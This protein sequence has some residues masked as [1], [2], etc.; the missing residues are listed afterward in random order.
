M[1]DFPEAADLKEHT[2]TEHDEDTKSGYMQKVRMQHFFVKLDITALQCALCEKDLLSVEDLIE[3]LKVEHEKPMFTDIKSHIMPFKFEDSK[4]KCSFCPHTFD[5]FKMLQEHMYTHYD[6]YVCDVC[7]AGFV[8]Q[9]MLANHSVSHK[10]GRFK[11]THCDEEFETIQKK[12]YHEKMVH[13]MSLNKCGYCDEKFLW[14]PQKCAHMAEVHGKAIMKPQECKAC[15]K[16]FESKR[17]LQIHVRRDHLLERRFKCTE[18]EMEFFTKALLKNHMV[19]HSGVKMFPCKVCNKSYSLMKGLREHMKIHNNDK[20][21]KCVQRNVNATIQ[22]GNHKNVTRTR[23]R[24]EEPKDIKIN[25]ITKHRSNIHLIL[26]CTNAT[27]IR[28]RGGIGYA[29]SFCA[30]EFPDPADLKKHTIEVHDD[31]AKLKFMHGKMMFS[32]KKSHEKSVH[33]HANLLNK[34]GYCQ[35]KFTNYKKKDEHLVKVHGVTMKTI[36]CHACDKT[37]DNKGALSTHTKRDHLM[38]RKHK[39]TECDMGFFL[40][41]ELKLHMVKHTGERTFKCTVCSKSYGRHKT[42]REHM[43]IHNDDRRFKCDHTKL[44]KESIKIVWS[45]AKREINKELSKKYSNIE[46]VLTFSNATPILRWSDLGYVCC[47]C[48][49]GFHDPADLKKHTIATHSDKCNPVTE[50]AGNVRRKKQHLPSV[51]VKLDITGLQCNKGKVNAKELEKVD[52]AVLVIVEGGKAVKSKATGKPKITSRSLLEKHQHNLKVILKSSNAT[53]ILRLGGVGYM[54]SYCFKEF[55]DPKDLKEHY[56]ESHPSEQAPEG[57]SRS[58]TFSEYCIKLDITNLCCNICDTEIDNLEE[59]SIHLQEDH[60]EFM[61]TNIPSHIIPFK[62]DS[63]QLTC[64]LCSRNFYRFKILLE[65]MHTHFRNYVCEI[66]DAGFINKG[67]LSRHTNI[68]RKGVFPCSFCCKVFDTNIK[69]RV[70]E[71]VHTSSKSLNRCGYCNEGFKEHH[72]KEVHLFEVH[73]VSRMDYKCTACD[74]GFD[75]KRKLRIHVKRDHLLERKHKCLYCDMSFFTRY[76]VKKHMIT[77]TGEK[78]FQCPVC[79]KAFGRKSTLVEHLRIHNDDRR[80][81]C[82]HCGMAFVQKYEE[83]KLATPAKTKKDPYTEEIG[84]NNEGLIETGIKKAPQKR[85]K[86]L[87]YK[88]LNNLKNILECTNATMILRQGDKGYSCCYCDAAYAKPSQLKVH[89]LTAHAKEEVFYGKVYA[90]GPS[91]FLVKLD[92]TDLK[93]T[94]CDTDLETLENIYEHLKEKHEKSFHMDIKN[95][96][97]PFRFNTEQLTC[98]LCPNNVVFDTFR[99]L[100]E[101]MH[102]HYRNFIC[103]ACD[104]GFINQISLKRHAVIHTKGTFKCRYCSL[105]FDNVFK[106]RNHEGRA[107]T[108]ADKASICQLCNE[109]FKEYWLKELHLTKAHGL[110]PKKFNCSACDKT[111]STPGRRLPARGRVFV[112]LPPVLLASDSA[113]RDRVVV[114]VLGCPRCLVVA[115]RVGRICVWWEWSCSSTPAPSAAYWALECVCGRCGVC[116]VCKPKE[117]IDDK[118]LNDTVSDT[119]SIPENDL[120]NEKDQDKVASRTDLTKHRNNIK[121]ILL[122][123]NATPIR[124]HVGIGYT[125]SYCEDQYVKAADLKRHTLDIHKKI[126]EANFMKNMN[127]S[128]YVVKVDITG[129]KC[130]GRGTRIIKI[131]KPTKPTVELKFFSKLTTRESSYS[132]AATETV[133]NR[134]NLRHILLNSNANTIRCKDALG[135]GCSFCPKQFQDPTVL[136]KHCLDEHNSDKLILRMTAKIFEYVIKLD[137]TYLNCALCDEDFDQLDEFMVHLKNVHNKPMCLDVKSYILP[138][139][140]DTPALKCVMCLAE[141]NSFKLLQEHMNSH[142]A[143][144]F[145]EI[146]GAGFVTDRLRVSHVRRHESGEYKCD[147]CEKTFANKIRL[148]EHNKRTHL[149]FSARNKCPYCSEKFNDYW[150]KMDHMIKEHGVEQPVLKCSACDRTFSTQRSLSVH[151]KKDHLMERRH[152][153]TECDMRFFGMSGL[154]KHMTKHTGLRQFRCEICLK[155]YGRKN[156]LREHMR[157]HA[158]DRRFVCVHCGQAFVQK[159]VQRNTRLKEDKSKREENNVLVDIEPKAEKQQETAKS[160]N[161]LKLILLHSNATLIR[162]K[163]SDGYGCNFCRKKFEQPKNLKAHSLEEHSD[164]QALRMPR[165]SQH[166]LKADITDLKCKICD[167]N[168]LK[169]DDLAEHLKKEHSKN[170]TS[171]I[172]EI[173]PF[174]FDNEG[175]VCAICGAGYSTFKILQE[176]MHNHFRNHVCE[177][178]S[179]GFVTKRLL[180]SHRRRHGGESQFKCGHCEKSFLCA[181]K[182]RD[183]EQRMHLGIKKRNK[184]KLCEEKFEDYWT[185]QNHMVQKHGAPPI[186]LK[187]TACDRTFNN[188]RSLT[189]HVKKDHLM[190]REHVCSV[191]NA[192]Y[193]LKRHL[194]EHMIMHTGLRSRTIRDSSPIIFEEEDKTLTLDRKLNFSSFV[195]IRPVGKKAIPWVREQQKKIAE[196]R[197]LTELDW[198]F[199]NIKTILKCSNAS[200]VRCRVGSRF[201]CSYCLDQFQNPTELRGHSIQVHANDKPEFFNARSL[202][203]HIVYL[204]I[205]GTDPD[206]VRIEIEVDTTL[207]MTDD[208]PETSKINEVDRHRENVRTILLYSNA[209]PIGRYG[210]LGYTC[211]YCPQIFSDPKDLKKHVIEQHDERNI[212]SYM[213][214]YTMLNYIVKLDITG[215][216][217]E[218]CLKPFHE[219]QGFIDHLTEEHDKF[220]HTDIGNH[221]VP[222]RF[223]SE[224]LRCVQCSFEY[225]NF[226]ILLEH[227]NTHFSNHICGVCEAG[228]VNRRMLQAHMYRHKTGVFRCSF[229]TKV[230]DTRVKMKVHERMVHL[231]LKKRPRCTIC[232][233]KFLDFQKMIEH[234]ANDHGLQRQFKCEMCSRMFTSQQSFK[235][236]KKLHCVTAE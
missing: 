126:T 117:N 154:K 66:C 6:N 16:I 82:Q 71:R 118:E 185:K 182:R 186:A 2:I 70:H 49:E 160:S 116:P 59:L 20:R 101:H 198:Q 8:N 148:R 92:I 212:S 63:D 103:D 208:E 50:P 39:C 213:K 53:P 24:I 48:K 64:C 31:K 178:C 12:R 4:L 170:I 234:E 100:H 54:C 155:A 177:V 161:D 102:K 25:E 183:H 226:K 215:L 223:D 15:N 73:G 105:I 34:C 104:A 129:L 224:N 55:P 14:Y 37:F 184:C 199:D 67:C 219:L 106:R 91:R 192:R 233:K 60:E 214:N 201:A 86:R 174:K 87:L 168:L 179:A 191:C 75:T 41:N 95:Q 124:R 36:R 18:C 200:P 56:F 122:N 194:M 65:H 187:C 232:G 134:A 111:F 133:K 10:V 85:I 151:T 167:K 176:H 162:N 84:S 77:H 23:R 89:T 47:Y 81:K 205:T 1:E 203:R 74:R 138:F 236:H 80:F 28:C 172:S 163:D 72:L 11:C 125:C 222:F 112:A 159:C 225:N 143:N 147:Q 130:H 189:R 109:G 221:I 93:C 78:E 146:C 33:I 57:C 228:F 90:R 150:K 158:N 40:P 51:S 98:C 207:F 132:L 175:L 135:Y 108:R 136:K 62:F 79:L 206:S 119:E 152:K 113:G 144:Y 216:R 5:R 230:F 114:W 110:T 142:F 220:F 9:R 202:S 156:T 3:H 190:E 30:D 145:C 88:H 52:S 140:F 27:P 171:G 17:K 7:H 96:I 121:E 217:C 235:I 35:M 94:L 128:E 193:F 38:E 69:K 45:K 188:R 169:L 22:L 166:L 42:L 107:H 149:G 115:E 26:Q 204:D 29:C 32:K 127:L 153:C 157:I 21:F 211:C 19:K 131:E 173:I 44:S 97:F 197:R 83:E 141:F 120:F 229:C 165:S 13:L 195:S 180:V 58:T 164:I 46:T 76:D 181:Q 209:T 210:S 61:Y 231:C 43:R 68:H 218:V 137:I 227:M 99:P 123:S 139:R 196:E